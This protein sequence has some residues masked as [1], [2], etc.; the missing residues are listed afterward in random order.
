MI[1][2]LIRLEENADY[3]TFGILKL[4]KKVFCVTLEPSDEENAPFIS[5]IPCQQYTCVRFTSPTF[6][7]TFQVT[8][9]PGRT[10][11]LFHP[12]NSIKDTEGC[13]LLAE[14]FGKLKEHRDVRNSGITFKNFMRILGDY[15]ECHLTICEVY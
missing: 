5:S 8:K 1:V 4:D 2:E 12:G 9:V 13:I 3:G 14:H 11:I 15:N 6:G 10:N 7:E